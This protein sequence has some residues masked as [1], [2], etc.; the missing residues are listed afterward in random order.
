MTCRITFVAFCLPSLTFVKG[1]SCGKRERRS[2]TRSS[3]KEIGRLCSAIK[4]HSLI[5]IERDSSR[6]VALLKRFAIDVIACRFKPAFEH[7]K[8]FLH[9][10][11][12]G[13]GFLSVPTPAFLV[14][15]SLNCLSVSQLSTKLCT[16]FGRF[17]FLE[18]DEPLLMVAI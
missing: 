1:V 11:Q 5:S 8:N 7:V 18:Q 17:H 6:V 14:S 15:K 12:N 16:C 10:L 3:D 13:C 9:V 2:S 4:E